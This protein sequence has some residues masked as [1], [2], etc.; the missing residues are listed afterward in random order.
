M[1]SL[2]A[3]CLNA[4][5]INTDGQLPWLHFF[6]YGEGGSGKTTLCATF[7]RP[8]LLV[9]KIENSVTTLAG[10]DVPYLFTD[11]RNATL[12]NG[13]GGLETIVAMLE[14]EYTANPQAFPFDT[15]CLESFSHYIEIFQEELTQG[16]KTAMDQRGWGLLATHVRNIQARLRALEVHV[17]FTALAKLETDAAGHTHGG[18]MLPG[19]T[20]AMLPTA[21]DVVAYCEAGTGKVPIYK[22]HFRRHNHFFARTRFKSLPAAI[23]NCTF[24]KMRP[25]LDGSAQ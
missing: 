25:F 1:S 15:I 16:N 11:G 3:K 2:L 21:C 13:C 23:E 17:V 5:T 12:R 4:Q 10:Q 20:A 24:E 19:K 14:N 8:L 9:P 18:P 22:T 7:P 6:V